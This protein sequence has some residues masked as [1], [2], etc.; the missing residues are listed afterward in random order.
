[1]AERLRTVFVRWLPNL[2]LVVA[3][4]LLIRFNLAPLAFGLLL[5]S[6]WQLFVGGPKTWLSNI[7][8]NSCDIIVAISSVTALALF[9]G[10]LVL[11]LSV[12]VGYGMW[13]LVI[14]SLTSSAGIALQA[15]ICQ[16]IGLTVLFLLG[17]AL[18]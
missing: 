1:M 15:G 8:D 16:T 4:V 11:Q 12:A 3:I 17:R 14:E 18:P 10:D 2:V 9:N 5:I 7:R 13:L 6:K